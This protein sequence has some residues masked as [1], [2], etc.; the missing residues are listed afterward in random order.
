[1]TSKA[2]SL[3]DGALLSQTSSVGTLAVVGAL[4]TTRTTLTTSFAHGA[5]L[6]EGS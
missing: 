3:G 4:L 1:M 5:L 6:P 2:P